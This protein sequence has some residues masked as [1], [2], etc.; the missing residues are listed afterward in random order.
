M[1]N[2]L[3]RDETKA[4]GEKVREA[5]ASDTEWTQKRLAIEL[6]VSQTTISNIIAGNQLITDVRTS[7]I[8]DLLGLEL[9]EFLH[10]PDIY[11]SAPMTTLKTGTSLRKNHNEVHLVLDA[12]SDVALSPYWPGDGVLD[13]SDYRDPRITATKNL[14]ALAQC[15]SFLLLY[16]HEVDGPSGALIELGYAMGLGLRVTL[17][18]DRKLNQKGPKP[19]ILDGLQSAA[20][21]IDVLPRID[22]HEVNNAKDVCLLLREN[23]AALVAAQASD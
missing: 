20:M 11:V 5:L 9:S 3:T 21:E 17:M 23:G 14:Q 2:K 6:G 10:R 8:A 18:I 13:H 12:L 16:L 4:V 15:S 7:L 22:I 19:F 1:A